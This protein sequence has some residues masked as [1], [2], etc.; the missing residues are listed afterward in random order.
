MLHLP[1]SSPSSIPS[2]VIT[3]FLYTSAKSAVSACLRT[4]IEF[5][6]IFGN[7]TLAKVFMTTFYHVS[8]YSF[9]FFLN[10]RIYIYVCVYCNFCIFLEMNTLAK[11]LMTTFHHARLSFLTPHRMYVYMCIIIFLHFLAHDYYRVLQPS[12]HRLQISL[13]FVSLLLYFVSFGF[14]SFSITYI[15]LLLFRKVLIHVVF[16]FPPF[17]Y[18]ANLLSFH[19]LFPLYH[20]SIPYFCSYL[21]YPKVIY[22]Y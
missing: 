20:H 19:F 12:S 17:L 3:L 6:S 7:D 13:V 4:F 18:I 22:F 11:V 1:A 5:T 8:H 14:V 10:H 15:P 16:W 9:S 2:P 21:L